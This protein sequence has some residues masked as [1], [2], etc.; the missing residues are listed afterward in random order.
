MAGF[1]LDAGANSDTSGAIFDDS[2]VSA[3]DATSRTGALDINAAFTT[4]VVFVV[5]TQL[6]GS[7]LR[8]FL[9]AYG[10][11]DITDVFVGHASMLASTG[12]ES[13][14]DVGF[15][16]DYFEFMMKNGLTSINTVVATFQASHGYGIPRVSK[17][18]VL[19]VRS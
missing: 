15:Q 11:N 10:D 7:E 8:V 6:T 18:V 12:N 17:Q 13:R 19:S 5:D 1:S 14:T 9:E 16:G 2:I 3:I 4:D